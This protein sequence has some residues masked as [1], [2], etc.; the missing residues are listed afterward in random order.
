MQDRSSGCQLITVSP[1]LRLSLLSFSLDAPTTPEQPQPHLLDQSVIVNE[2][3]VNSKPSKN[4]ARSSEVETMHLAP[5]LLPAQQ[6]TISLL[7]EDTADTLSVESLTLVPPVDPHSL[8][9]LTGIPQNSTLAAAGT[10]T[11]DEDTVYPES[12]SPTE[13]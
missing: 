7:Y 8:R 3:D 1:E 4:L 9:A 11:P 6:P 12:A 2:M 5:S 10:E 13:H